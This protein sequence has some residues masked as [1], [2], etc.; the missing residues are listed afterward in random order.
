MD[1][2]L[3]SKA[4]V[5]ERIAT[6]R[7]VMKTEGID[8]YLVPSSDPH[9]SEYLPERWQ[10]RQYL[11]GFTGSMGTLMVW[12]SGAGVWADSRYFTQAEAE[13]AGTGI[14]LMRLAGVGATQHVDWLAAN[15]KAGQTVGVDGTVLGL[16][17]HRQLEAAL[18]AQ[19]IQLRT[20][21]DLMNA[22]WPARPALPSAGVYEHTAPHAV[23]SREDKLQ[24]VRAAMQAAGAD[25]HF[26]STLDDIAWLYNLRGSD[27]SYNP[28]FIAHTLI[29]KT[30]A[31]L[32]VGEAKVNAALA[33]S[34]KTQGV[35]VLPYAQCTSE[36]AKL[37]GTVMLD[38]KR[39]TFGLRQAVHT[40]AK[41]AEAINP[42]TLA[43]SRKTEAEAAHI[44]EA[45]R[46]D[47]AA[48]AEFYAWFENALASKLHITELTIDE[49]LSAARSKR[50]GFVSL[51]FGTIAGYN[52]NGAMPHYHATHDSHAVIEGDGMLLI[53]SGGQYLGG[54]TDITRVWPIGTISA[55]M[56]R[57][58]T[59]VL[60]G[61]IALSRTQFPRGTLSPML[62]AIARAPL[63]QAGLEYG[64]GTGHGVGYFMNVHEG[65]QSI[66]KTIPDA[67]MA[68]QPG[69]I[70]SIEPGLY[71][72]GKWGVRIENL[73]MN[74]D[75]G[76][77]EFGEFLKFETLTLCPIDTRLIDKSLMNADEIAWLNGYHATVWE[78]VSPL[79]SGE[80]KRWLEQ[81]CV[82]L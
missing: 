1:T 69:M 54:T 41:I 11:S 38:P 23:I 44:R 36:L 25:W 78:R 47:G 63:W 29:S 66:S 53:D 35:E 24:L 6:L 70:T 18:T 56:Q 21:C 31:L 81:R 52:A 7:N 26:I 71:R 39:V 9:L 80:A 33:E 43:K 15:L 65:P 10:A 76:T 16:A 13:L 12:Q 30:T 48:M 62:D 8:A 72:P 61:T 2:L 20:D 60:K 42:S 14:S 46:Q 55:A 45:M 19:G 64:H 68:M 34:L 32:F 28:V 79:V 27:V 74:V 5:R 58:Y 37:S 4:Q 75:A 49:K 57:D 17:A 59:L 40:Q 73:V 22:V 51:S 67:N 77:T 82:A 50:A 3:T